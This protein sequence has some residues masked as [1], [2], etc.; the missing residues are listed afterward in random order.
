MKKL[1]I[2]IISLISFSYLNS[3][4]D[5]SK[6]PKPGPAPEIKLSS[7]DRFELP[8][9]LKVFV[10]ENHQLPAVSLSLIVDRDP[11]MEKEAAGY[12]EMAGELLRTGTKNRTKDQLDEEIDFIGASINTS[13]NSVYGSALKKHLGKLA[14]LMSDI[15]INPVFKQEELDKIK[16]KMISNLAAAKDEPETIAGRV[17]RT[18]YYGKDHPYSEFE[19]EKTVSN[20]T[21][22]M[23]SNYYT[24]FFRPN[25]SYL[26]VVGDITRKEI[27]PVI[28]KYFGGWQKADV[29]RFTYKVPEVPA[30][31]RV[32]LVDRPAS[33]QTTLRVG[34][35]VDLKP[36]A[37]DVIKSNVTNT[38]LGGG[39]FRLFKNLR[40]KHAYTYGAYSN[41]V[42]DKW[43]GN[44]TASANVKNAVTDSAVSEILF[45]M[46]RMRDE[47]PENSELQQAKNYSSGS[48]ALSLEKPETIALFAINIERYGLPKD[49]YSTYLKKIAA[50]STD[51][52][53]AMAKK[54]IH[55]GNSYI[56]AVGKA[57][58]I[59]EK[60]K[61]FSPEAQVEYYDI[62]GEKYDP[63]ASNIPAGVDAHSVIEKYLKALGGRE[64]MLNVKD[65]LTEM[66]GKVQGT[67][68][69]INI[70]QK[71]PNKLYQE[72][73]AGGMQQK[74]VFNGEKAVQVSPMGKQDI[75]GGQLEDLKMEANLNAILD[76]EK[77]G[78]KSKLISIEKI[79]GNDAYKLEMST[80]DRTWYE[81]YDVASGL[82]LRLVKTMQT[83]MGQ[84]TQTIDF[85]D[86]R[87]VNGI[88][89]PF[90]LKQSVGQQK[91]DMIVNS[92]KVNSGL[93]DELFDIS[94]Y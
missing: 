33:V 57:S 91:I 3:Q 32:A 76:L 79:E 52:I 54:Y 10:V 64:K 31:V 71:Q 25:I 85:A 35:P 81:Y 28:K 83:Q 34:H 62:Y 14:E 87:D 94:K 74:I 68:I 23:C 12:V 2:I 89:Y 53:T 6:P 73:N 5:R 26:A 30:A 58:D 65:R 29:K 88:K 22:E 75:S 46:K 93:G 49:Y 18:L 4:T 42:A 44:F 45:E 61:R 37:P 48:F 51:D 40:E 77:F 72:I 20:I 70:Y 90:N 55:P 38:I 13:S 80:G 17:T 7:Y 19:T 78:I 63:S 59:A 11:L 92:I 24:S 69:N 1:I 86:Y 41:L 47:R 8:N 43:I 66:T 67:S 9:G 60:L 39:V 56:I 82:K 50:V 15:V 16:T 36:G 21:L 84:M 27:E